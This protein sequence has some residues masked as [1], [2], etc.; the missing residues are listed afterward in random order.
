MALAP[1]E[2]LI[3][4]VSLDRA[5]YLIDSVTKATSILRGHSNQV[6]GAIFS[7]DGKR[8]AT[9]DWAGEV[10]IWNV[11]QR[12]M[13]R[14][15]KTKSGGIKQLRFTKDDR[16]LLGSAD[17]GTARLWDAQSGKE[18]RRFTGH[19]NT[20]FG[21]EISPDEKWVA[22]ASRDGTAAIYEFATS[23]RVATLRDHTSWVYSVAFNP[24]GT[25]LATA[26]KDGTVRLWDITDPRSPKK[27]RVLHI[28]GREVL[29][30][31]FNPDGTTLVAGD[32]L[33]WATTWRVSTGETVSKLAA[34]KRR[35]VDLVFDR[36]GKRMMTSS[37]D[38]TVALWRLDRSPPATPEGHEGPI[39][40]MAVAPD[41]QV[42]ATGGTDTMVR[43]WRQST[44]EQLRVLRGH[45]QNINSLS[46][47]PKGKRI[48]SG[49]ND[50]SV[51]IWDAE[52][53]VSIASLHGHAGEVSSVAYS[54]D[55]TMVAS[56][57][58]DTTIALWE[59]ATQ[60]VSR[61]LTGHTGVVDSLAFSPDG[62]S[63]ASAS[64]DKSVRLWNVETGHSL[65]VMR[66]HTRPTVDVQFDRTG[67]KLV[68]SGW[69]GE[70]RVWDVASGEGQRIGQDPGR[71]Y[72]TAFRP[73]GDG[74]LSA[75]SD[76]HGRLWSLAE[77]AQGKLS[78]GRIIATHANEVNTVTINPLGT[79]A[80]T[81]SDDHTVRT[82]LVESGRPF[83]RAPLALP[84]PARLLSHRG[85]QSLGTTPPQRQDL[86]GPYVQMAQR[87]A[88]G[89]ASRKGDLIC[90]LSFSKELLSWKLS[91]PGPSRSRSAP[92]AR[93]LIATPKGCLMREAKRVVLITDVA[94]PDADRVLLQGAEVTA[95]A[96]AA[97]RI[98]VATKSNV[99]Q[100]DSQAKLLTSTVAD[101]GTSAVTLI[102]HGG[103]SGLSLVLGYDN[104]SIE[105]RD[106]EG[107]RRPFDR[108]AA[109]RVVSLVSGPG[110]TVIAGHANGVVS[111]YDAHDGR[112]LR[113]GELHGQVVHLLLDDNGKGSTKLHA[114]TDLASHLTWDLSVFTQDRCALLQQVWQSV[115]VV[116]RSGQ[117][118]IEPPPP[119]HPC[120][121][122]RPA[123][124]PSATQP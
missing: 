87:L 100:F 28:P 121:P 31:K 36:A 51:R 43:L 101:A 124:T 13:S 53:G 112:R 98:V 12:K 96:W 90:G 66:G 5:V 41:G 95:I 57:S 63:L 118:T 120:R 61:R 67:K 62:K 35:I 106:R 22:S 30:A 7:H 110:G 79:I 78:K 10:R 77:A 116:W 33:G 45:Q 59:V 72:S 9:A 82:W 75:S 93:E 34:H 47:G 56:G 38:G 105:V 92:L 85:L 91:T 107:I 102:A 111:L 52:T 50:G 18:V 17:D 99:Q 122:A 109:S 83:W 70:I 24:D 8:L 11:S 68:S 14:A 25:R 114:A 49:S 69:D 123:P 108:A 1:D 4:A 117:P 21:M 84:Q 48:V 88:H 81:G 71:V 42:I 58:R 32:S 55:G 115:P 104:G 46:F 2:R 94:R 54:P 86:T 119:D 113:G 40:G 37:H 97:G 39:Y 60:K 27:L 23:K 65:Q 64:W 6:N 3:A 103:G 29:V 73:Q 15:I 20:V 16:L 76:R 19:T 44:G 80:A 89:S 74:V 26:G